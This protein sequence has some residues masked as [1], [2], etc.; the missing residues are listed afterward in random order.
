MTRIKIL[1]EDNHLLVIVKP[2]G[3]ATQ[4]TREE[5]SI[6]TWARD[7][8]KEKYNKPGNVYIGVVSRLDKPVSGVLVL[9]R[10]SKAAAR[11][12]E[13]FRQSTITKHYLAIV[14][15]I[16]TT[17][18]VES[19]QKSMLSIKS[20][21]SVWHDCVNWIAKSERQQRMTVV[22]QNSPQAIEAR[23]RWQCLQTDGKHSLLR[24]DLLTGRKHQ[25]RVQL[26]HLGCPIVG[27]QKYGLP[28]TSGSQAHSP[29]RRRGAPLDD[30]PKR[31]TR[32]NQN[33]S[34]RI[35]LH[36]ERL[37]LHHPVG[38]REM[39]FVARIPAW[40]RQFSVSN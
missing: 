18:G 29:K 32:P 25:I 30:S 15:G 28:R 35:A 23:L 3:I 20:D 22:S 40:W 19:R 10:T 5:P 27:D 6:V 24:I 37:L 39:E 21:A 34:P 12:S 8:L 1:Y 13:Q 4:G 33:Q 14:N 9:A 26:A 17:R 36:A 31:G 38:G 2:A 16:P 7:Y 11:L